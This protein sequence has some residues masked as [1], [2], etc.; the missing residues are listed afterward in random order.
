[1]DWVSLKRFG[2]TAEACEGLWISEEGCVGI[3]EREPR[4]SFLKLNAETTFG[5]IQFDA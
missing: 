1:M 3:T 4:N 5:A 2:G